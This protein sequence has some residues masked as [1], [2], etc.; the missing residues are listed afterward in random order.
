MVDKTKDLKAAGSQ[1]PALYQGGP[2]RPS[3][4]PRGLFKQLWESPV[5]SNLEDLT[6]YLFQLPVADAPCTVD[7]RNVQPV[8]NFYR[9][10][11]EPN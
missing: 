11:F 3:P 5:P 7:I 8:E 9:S 4:S 2:D 1:S 10:L 6:E